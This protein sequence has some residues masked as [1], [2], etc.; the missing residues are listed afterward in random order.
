MYIYINIYIGIV[1]VQCLVQIAN[2]GDWG[3]T[4]HT[5]LALARRFP[6]ERFLRLLIRAG[7]SMDGVLM[8]KC[9]GVHLEVLVHIYAAQN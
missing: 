1:A 3:A 2:V 7:I 9:D 5:S 4:D 6:G 8:V